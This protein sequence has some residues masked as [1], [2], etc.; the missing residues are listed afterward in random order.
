MA[1]GR[2]SSGTENTRARGQL[3]FR[4]GGNAKFKDNDGFASTSSWC[5]SDEY[6]SSSKA[7]RLY[8]ATKV[9]I[10]TGQLCR[11]AMMNVEKGDLEAKKESRVVVNFEG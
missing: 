11:G 2:L 1:E 8:V 5:S 9:S 6:P 3:T 10:L 4:S 7:G